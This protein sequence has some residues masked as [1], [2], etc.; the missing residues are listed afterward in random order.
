[1]TTMDNLMRDVGYAF[2]RLARTPGFT[3][4]GVLTLALGIGANTAIFS[5]VHSVLYRD[6]AARAPEEL[7]ELYTG[8]PGGTAYSTFSHPDLRDVRDAATVFQDVAARYPA[9]VSLDN[10]DGEGQVVLGEVVTPNLFV[11]LGVDAAVGRTFD[12]GEN[13]ES[14]A[15]PETV[16][17][18]RLWQGH[19]GGDPGVV[20]RTVQLNGRSVTVIG[21]MSPAFTGQFP[22]FQ[23]D[24]WVP[25]GTAVALNV[26]TVEAMG[27]RGQR[28]LFPVARLAPGVTVAEAK[29]QLDVIAGRLEGAHPDSNQ[30]RA[31]TLLPSTE[32]AFNPEVDRAVAPVA[33]LLTV[34]VGLVLAIACANLA[35]LLLVRA[36]ERRK[37]IATRLA[38][39]GGRGRLV[40]Q[41]LTE[42]VVLA[43]LGGAVGL[44]VAEGLVTALT[45]LAPPTP[46]PINIDI[47]LDGTV[48]AFAFG[49]SLATGV[50]FGLAPALQAARTNMVPALRDGTGAT[51]GGRRW[52]TLR[53]ALVVGQVTVSLVLLVSAGL[54][55]RSLA[56]TRQVDPGFDPG[57]L[58]VATLNLGQYGYGPDEAGAF[59]DLLVERL[60][61]SPEV[62]SAAVTSRVPLGIGLH[63]ASFLPEEQSPPASGSPPRY[64][65]ARVD[66]KYFETMD[67]PM[68]R[69]RPFTPEDRV[70]PAVA[71]VSETAAHHFWPGDD[72]VGKRLRRGT[73]GPVYEVVGVARDTKVRTLGETPRPYVYLSRDRRG[74]TIAAVVVAARG[75]PAEAVKLLRTEIRRIDPSVTSFQGGTMEEQMAILLY[76]VRMGAMLIAAFGALALIL[77]TTGLYGVVSYSASR[78]TREMGIRMAMGARS[79][80]IVGV[81]IRDGAVL[82]G[83]GLALG[84]ALAGLG[85]RVLGRFLFGVGTG[86][87]LTFVVVSVLLA[88]VALLASW[89]PARGAARLAPVRALRQP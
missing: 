64:D 62:R 44:A 4:A 58:A 56:E 39:G 87:A 51:G 46:L 81:V 24:L 47:Q 88:C 14:R 28:D 5:L 38:I 30:G 45:G 15:V 61:A 20:G 48:L 69:G 68:V 1:M 27:A 43:L 19:F 7:V 41:L 70:G 66:Q 18:H 73:D 80:D 6:L 17:S 54:F 77:A 34:V 52:L 42:S 32:V 31:M 33:V 8:E 85:T 29:A 72:P 65:Y 89:V 23:T 78:R 22:A 67:V 84:L 13:A 26:E 36:E 35:S 63:L 57:H 37:E 21:V 82:L 83:V 60:E 53:H 55:V 2:R 25:T 76:P 3:A 40:G 86:D 71:I 75:H 49:I 11:L 12:V 59:L 9:M 74:T 50:L 16:L 10:G 79:H